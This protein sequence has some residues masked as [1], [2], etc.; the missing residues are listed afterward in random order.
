MM[1]RKIYH[2][3]SV[4]TVDIDS[5]IPKSHLLRTI[6]KHLDLRFVR[7]LA[8]P[9]YC[10]DNGRPSID[11][12]V[13]FRIQLLIYLY[14]IESDRQVIEELHYNLAYRW[15]CK[16]TL[17]DTIPDHSSLTRIRD[18]LGEKTFKKIFDRIVR[19]C[20]KRGLSK[21]Q[22]IM[23][24]GSLVKA[25]AA[26]N[27]L[28]KRR[29][30]DTIEKIRKRKRPKYIKGRKYSNGTH[31]SR[32][33]PDAKLAGK[34]T[35]LKQIKYKVH[36]IADLKSRVIIDTHVTDG[37]VPEGTIF[38]DRLDQTEKTFK[39]KT[40]VAV[41]DRG[42]GS[43]ENLQELEN[44][45]IKSFVPNF[46]SEVGDNY[47]PKLF[48]YDKK[49]DVFTCPRGFE[50]LPTQFQSDFNQHQKLY[51]LLGGHCKKCPL[52]RKCFKNQK[53][54]DRGKRIFRNLHCVIQAKTKAREKTKEFKKHRAQ[55]QWKM[56]GLFAEAKTFHG[57]DR[58]RYRLRANMQIQAYM[59]ASV[60]NIKRLMKKPFVTLRKWLSELTSA[61]K[62]FSVQHASN[63]QI[64]FY[65]G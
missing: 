4:V 19:E 26:L 35:E 9:L 15:F 22:K 54:I 46:H 57:L 17:E 24:D 21:S 1:G 30:G 3:K 25:D 33:D 58:A 49:K 50:L 37:S 23:A 12:E 59:T 39:F 7:E 56:E 55:R 51:R 14:N 16:F 13:F 5:L 63:I 43:G 36:N 62:I 20:E 42:Y 38:F 32:T 60:Q 64:R 45:K 52:R 31:V 27:S 53:K 11:P 34:F 65:P 8:R 40:K 41:A 29:E 48:K 18:R 2:P 61:I 6:E 44:R 10:S 28:I 47:D